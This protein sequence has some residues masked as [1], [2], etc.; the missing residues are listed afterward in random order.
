MRHSASPAHRTD[1]IDQQIAS[2]LDLIHRR[3]VAKI[4]A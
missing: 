1:M 2:G 4:A 3:N